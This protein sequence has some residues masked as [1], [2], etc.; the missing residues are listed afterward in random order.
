MK[1]KQTMR[2]CWTKPRGI[3]IIELSIAV[4][5]VG[6]L[7]ALAIPG[8]L[9]SI[10]RSGVDGASRR[11]AE[12]IRLA[13]SNAITRGVQA[14]LVAFDQTGVA[15]NPPSGT[16]LSDVSKANKYRIEIRS[17]ASATWPAVT[18][19]P[20]S[21]SNILTTWHDISGQYR[22]V[23]VTT[24][25]ALL[26]NSQGFLANSVIPLTI[27]LQGSGGTKTVQTSVIG[28]ATVQ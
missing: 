7:A 6:I 21:N 14:R 3:N 24:G 19:T 28:K 13:Q 20:G 8:I 15:P 4:S 27:V 11:L 22:G 17:G 12:D 23:V 2:K 10:Q 16:N 1:Q 9:G 26:F 25:N 18:D 5:I